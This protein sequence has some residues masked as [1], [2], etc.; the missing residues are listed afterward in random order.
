MGENEASIIGLYPW[1]EYSV[2]KDAAFCY[3]CHIFGKCTEHHSLTKHGFSD[4]KHALGSKGILHLHKLFSSHKE[5][6]IAWSNYLKN[7]KEN[8]SVV[9]VLGIDR[10]KRI[11]KNRHYLKCVAEI[12]LLCCAQENA[13][14]SHHKTRKIS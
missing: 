2:H 7:Q 3:P 1:L 13:L 5:V 6:V 8:T 12:I 4:W 14:R 11:Q 9:D 10:R